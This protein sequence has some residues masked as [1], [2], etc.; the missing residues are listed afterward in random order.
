MSALRN[1]VDSRLRFAKGVARRLIIVSEVASFAHAHYNHVEKPARL[2][3]RP[4]HLGRALWIQH[5]RKLSLSPPCL[6]VG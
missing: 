3:V 4:A 1:N 5:V 2:F 6:D